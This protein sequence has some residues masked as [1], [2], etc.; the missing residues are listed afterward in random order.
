M[1]TEHT[2][3]NPAAIRLTFVHEDDELRFER[4]TRVAMRAPA[5]EERRRTDQYTQKQR[6]EQT[7]RDDTIGSWVE[8]RDAN[9]GVLYRRRIDRPV[10]R[11]V[12][13]HDGGEDGS[14]RRVE[15]GEMSS[16]VNVL[17]P[18]LEDAHTV[19]VGERRLPSED[20]GKPS[21]IEYA[22][23]KLDDVDESDDDDRDDDGRNGRDKH[24]TGNRKDDHT[25]GD[26]DEQ[27][28]DED[29]QRG[30]SEGR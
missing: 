22:E 15:R 24:A 26:G 8:V 20:R 29:A 9:D 4:A 14:F 28:D 5:G 21:V 27:D 11:D 17:V 3:G 25:A 18:D 6:E 2:S 1:S 19:V 30:S 13:V 16:L 23:V 10:R 7:G 12:E